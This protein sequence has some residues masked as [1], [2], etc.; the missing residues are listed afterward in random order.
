MLLVPLRIVPVSVPLSIP[1]P[2]ATLKIIVV[3]LVTSA[4]VLEASCDCTVTLKATPAVPVVGTTEYASLVG[5]PAEKTML[6]LVTGLKI[7]PIVAVAVNVMVAADRKS[8][9]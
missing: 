3:L 2:L 7:I 4:G 6:S 5:V 1:E 8:V 9:V